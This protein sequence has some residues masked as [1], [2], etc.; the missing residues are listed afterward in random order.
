MELLKAW[1]NETLPSSCRQIDHFEGDLCNGYL[2]GVLLDEHGLLPQGTQL[3]DSEAP[4]V[5]VA[6]LTAIQQPLLD[7]GVKFNSK[8]ANDLMTETKGV[9]INMMYQLKLGLENA[10]TGGGGKPVVRRGKK[11]AVLLG[12]TLKATRPMLTTHER[13]QADHFEG[14]VKQQVQDPKQLAQAL[15]LSKFT[16]HMIEQQRRDEELDELRAKQYTAMVA[17]RRQ[18]EL[19]KLHEGQR[20]MSEWQADG[21]AKHQINLTRRKED[22]KAKLRFEL[23]VRTK[24]A[25]TLAKTHEFHTLDMQ[26]GVHEFESTLR[27]LQSDGPSSDDAAADTMRVEVGAA[28]HLMKLEAMLPSAASMDAEAKQYLGRLRVKRLEEEAGRKEREMRRRKVMLEQDAAQAQLEEKRCEELVLSKLA[29][30][31][32][33]ERQIGEQLWIARKEKDAMRHNRELR[34]QQLAEAARQ[35]ELARRAHDRALGEHARQEYMERLAREREAAAENES[36]R[37]AVTRQKHE[38]TCRRIA[39]QLVALAGRVVDFRATAAPLMPPKVMRDWTAL[40]KAGVPLDGPIDVDTPHVEELP[41]APAT[42]L[43]ETEAMLH[44]AELDTY[45]IGAADW[46][47]PALSLVRVP[48]DVAVAEVLSSD[49]TLHPAPA[50][51]GCAQTGRMVLECIEACMP[52]PPVSE[53]ASLPDQ[54]VKV[55]LLGRPYSGTSLQAQKL[56][57]SHRLFAILPAEVVASSVAACK[58]YDEQ[59]AA[60]KAAAAAGLEGEAAEAAAAAAAAAVEPPAHVPLE[61]ARRAAA[62]LPGPVP[63]D[64]LVGLIVGAIEAIDHVSY[65]GFVL[66]DFPKTVAQALLL[67]KAL[68]GFEPPPKEPPKKGSKV[69]PPPPADDPSKPPR[70]PGLDCVL[71]LDLPEETARRRALG[72]R[73]DPKTGTIY[74]LEFEPPQETEDELGP[75]FDGIN[76]RLVH[77]EGAADAEATLPMALVAYKDAEAAL[78]EWYGPSEGV[79]PAPAPGYGLNLLA[80]VGGEASIEEVSERIGVAIAEKLQLKRERLGAREAFL[81]EGAAAAAA[82]AAEAEAKVAEEAAKVAKLAEAAA[83]GLPP[84]EDALGAV[85]AAPAALAPESHEVL[86]AQWQALEKAY[87]SAMSSTFGTMRKLQ[88]H[89]LQRVCSCRNEFVELLT[90]PDQREAEA[91]NAQ[92]KFNAM[93]IELRLVDHGK[94]ELHMIASDLQEALYAHSDRRRAE[95]EAM[96]ASM[97]S[98]G[99]LPSHALQLTQALLAHVQA[100]ADRYSSTCGL[101]HAYLS[102]K[103]ERTLP[104]AP[105]PLAEVAVAE[106]VEMNVPPPGDGAPPPPPPD[107][108]GGKGA[109]PAKGGK[110]AKGAAPAAAVSPQATLAQ[111]VSAL[112]ASHCEPIEG[113]APPA[114][115]APGPGVD[116]QALR[117]AEYVALLHSVLLGERAKLRRR[118]VAILRYGCGAVEGLR[119]QVAGTFK[120]LDGWLGQRQKAESVAGNSLVG[121]MRSAIEAEATLPLSL[122]LQGDQLIIDESLLML[123]P[124]PPPPVPPPRQDPLADQFTVVQLQRLAKSLKASADGAF[125]TGSALKDVLSRLG[126][127]GFDASSPPL[128]EQWWPL[129][130]SQYEQLVALFCL[131]GSPQVAWADVLFALAALPPPSEGAIVKMLNAAAA[132]AGKHLDATMPARVGLKLSKAQYDELPLWIQEGRPPVPP[133]AYDVIGA[134]KAVLFEALSVDDTVDVQQLLLYACDTPAKAFACLGFHTQRMLDVAGMYELLHRTPAASSLEPPEHL[135]PYSRATLARLFTDLKLSK[136]DKAPYAAVVS[137]PS[138]AAML[139]GCVAYKPKDVYA[140]VGEITGAAGRSLL[141]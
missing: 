120:Q 9:G 66:D 81:Q 114:P 106:A 65:A 122:Q 34:D 35:S 22:E 32:Q 7:L 31:S 105:P 124:E 3:Q 94:A 128:P 55:A 125:L 118:L 50:E 4:S 100:E 140:K 102:L 126:A 88:W 43:A 95:C 13:M 60:T 44:A 80:S 40:F 121:L 85:A 97:A 87:V 42:A 68:T 67:E 10:K 133:G 134:T 64:V 51:S 113:A 16:E 135:D 2:L 48:A 24:H 89:A 20:L 17:Q 8:L 63:D 19:A 84:P 117:F 139:R 99:W 131:P 57:T 83:A 137:H 5:K 129:G 28:E 78:A 47:V 70:V 23:T 111:A 59:L 86:F 74:H 54:M 69:A 123:P 46:S 72:R 110:D 21:Y 11:E 79:T 98:D 141:L 45:L 127:A 71:R 107:A 52:P 112:V 90:G 73:L 29:R 93:P 132:L 91:L 104:F 103:A 39:E 56:V 49:A 115:P 12:S 36:A 92:Q 15:S 119:E 18:L 33:E 82:A 58:R 62:A 38:A 14:L 25:A 96:L 136:T 30:Q 76:G 6:N 108:K 116:A 26:Q 101:V 75:T 41:E 1:A 130:P 61:L 37:Q 77:V 27:R 53:H 138:G 109:P